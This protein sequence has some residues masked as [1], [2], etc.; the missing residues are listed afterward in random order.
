[1]S[2]AL[3]ARASSG[4]SLPCSVDALQHGG[5]AILQLAQVAEALLQ[6]AQ[7]RVVEAAGLLLAVARDERHRRA[8]AEQFHGG[9]DLPRLD[10]EFFGDARV[11]QSS[12]CFPF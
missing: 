1:M 2:A 12:T 8:L 6:L 5:A 9:G 11:D 7:L 10:V 4:V 3:I